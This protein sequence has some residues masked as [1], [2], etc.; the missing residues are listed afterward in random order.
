MAKHNLLMFFPKRVDRAF[1][2]QAEQNGHDE[3]EEYEM[4]E[5]DPKTIEDE[6]QL[7][8]KMEKGDLAAMIIAAMGMMIPI[9]IILLVL[10]IV[11]AC[12]LTG[13]Y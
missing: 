11:I 9:A 4:E 10:I 3:N 1:E 2:L 5:F 7:A 8:D 13:M 12:L 6:V